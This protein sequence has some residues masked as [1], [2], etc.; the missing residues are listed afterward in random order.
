MSFT[1]A[2]T[3]VCI[4]VCM[5]IY[6][7]KP[8]RCTCIRFGRQRFSEAMLADVQCQV[9]SFMGFERQGLEC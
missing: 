9:I 5:C 8:I 7:I 3:Y 2:H 6:M 4:C 1:C